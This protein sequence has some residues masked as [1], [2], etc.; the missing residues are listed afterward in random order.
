MT[1]L[2][3]ST[4]ATGEEIS[5]FFAEFSLLPIRCIIDI[6]E[7]AR[8]CGIAPYDVGRTTRHHLAQSRE[9]LAEWVADYLTG[10]LS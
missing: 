9:W 1:A 2:P 7:V 4:L 5:D 3:D 8:R 6:Y 10:Q